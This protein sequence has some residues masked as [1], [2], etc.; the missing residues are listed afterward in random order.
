MKD[1]AYAPN[2]SVNIYF[3]GDRFKVVGFVEGQRVL[4]ESPKHEKAG[5]LVGS[6]IW[7]TP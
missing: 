3:D 7:R 4:I 2:A 1:D 6:R 5:P